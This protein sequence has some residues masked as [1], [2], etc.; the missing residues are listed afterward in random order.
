MPVVRWRPA[1]QADL[2]A[3]Y[4]WIAGEAVRDVAFDYTSAVEARTADLAT[5]PERG[6]PR[7]DLAP[8]IRTVVHRRRTV[9]AYRLV[10][11][12]VEIVRLAHAGRDLGR[13]FDPEDDA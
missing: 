2:L 9:I 1:A 6:T 10:D 12:A 11:G 3:L 8:G 7:G 13:A 4:D 5:F